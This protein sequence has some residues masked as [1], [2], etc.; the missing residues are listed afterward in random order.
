MPG[1][2]MDGFG[3]SAWHVGDRLFVSGVSG[4]LLELDDATNVW[5]EAG[6]LQQGRFFHRLLPAHD[7]SLLAIAGA[8][9]SGHLTDIER[10]ELP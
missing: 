2:G 5:K 7:G 3:V 1:T 8:S 9:L 6:Q 4:T 10:V